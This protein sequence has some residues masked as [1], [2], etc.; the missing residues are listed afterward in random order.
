MNELGQRIRQARMERGW[1]QAQLADELHVTR[2]TISNWE[3]GRSIP[4]YGMLSQL[5]KLLALDT[6][7]PLPDAAQPEAEPGQAEPQPPEDTQPER[8]IIRPPWLVWAAA[9]LALLLCV[10]LAVH[11][12]V[13]NARSPYTI[14]W[15]S[16]VQ[17]PEP[18]CA[19]V[20]TYSLESPAKA[21]QNRPEATPMYQ[22]PIF[23][24]EENGVGCTI[25]EIVLVYFKGNRVL[26]IDSLAQ[27][28]FED[29]SLGTPYIAANEYRRMGRSWFAGP[30]T[31]IGFWIRG[32]DDNGNPFESKYYLPLE[33]N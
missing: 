8:R 12:L 5:T 29:N 2:Q 4:D 15:F 21:R 6:G 1:T 16:Q 24:K 22:F 20:R 10:L 19:A 25:H 30:E 17:T 9:G 14:E 27:D 13:P 32:I 23:M 7:F 26:Y 18:G 28:D 33:R 3:N 11:W 31:G